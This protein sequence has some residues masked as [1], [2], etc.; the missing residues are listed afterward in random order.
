MD[1]SGDLRGVRVLSVY[2][3]FESR[4]LVDMPTEVATKLLSADLA[5]YAPTLMVDSIQRELDKAPDAVALSP[6]AAL[7]LSMGF[8]IAHPYNSATSKSM[9]A[10]A[11]M[12]ALRELRALAPAKRERDEVDELRTRRDERRL[13]IAGATDSMDA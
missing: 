9:C 1:E 8:E 5:S 6:L 7:S 11:L 10:K 3:P 13:G 12:D 4:T 2:G